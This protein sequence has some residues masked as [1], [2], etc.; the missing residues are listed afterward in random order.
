[1]AITLGVNN[2][3]EFGPQNP[4]CAAYLHD[5]EGQIILDEQSSG[6]CEETVAPVSGFKFT[7]LGSSFAIG[8]ENTIGGE[9]MIYDFTVDWGDGNSDR[10]TSY[11]DSGLSHTYSGSSTYEIEITGSCPNLA[12]GLTGPQSS[13]RS[14]VRSI[15]QWGNCGFTNLNSAFYDCYNMVLALTDTP[16]FTGVTDIRWMFVECRSITTGAEGWNFST[17]SFTS[18]RYLFDHCDNFNSDCSGWN[19]TGITDM[20]GLFNY[21]QNFNND[22]SG[23]DTSAVTNMSFMFFFCDIFNH[24]SIVNL[25][26]S[27][28]TNFDRMLSF[29]QA[30][31]QD[32][33]GW[34]IPTTLG[35][36]TMVGMFNSCDDFN[37]IVDTWDVSQV[38]NMSE[39]FQDAFAFNQD[40]PTWDTGNVTDMSYMFNAS[41]GT[42]F[43]V[44]NGNI[45]GFDTSSVTTMRKMLH[46]CNEFNHDISGWDITSLTTAQDFMSNGTAF[47]TAN[48]DLLLNAWA[49][50]VV[51]T[52]VKFRVAATYTIATSQTAHDTLAVT[53]T[54]TITDGG[55]I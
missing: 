6:L 53:N 36:V 10:I 50:Q 42:S 25:D 33:S 7:I 39:M 34:T 17:G 51:N 21:C 8:L 35:P 54:W 16:N 13:H 14:K 48:Y 22:I 47:T 27:A 5:E 28:C 49:A 26:T 3:H 12:L 20:Q 24:A 41:F 2:M 32:I 43:G 29:A 23:L 31:N 40:F 45:T 9:T 55:G 11:N 18:M 19:T 30:L 46:N 1:M 15:T 37:Q 38:T 44:F 4:E 52:G